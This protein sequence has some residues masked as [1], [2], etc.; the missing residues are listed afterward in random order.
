TSELQG[1]VDGLHSGGD[2]GIFIVAEVGRMRAGRHD[3]TVVGIVGDPSGDGCS[4]H[5]PRLEVEAG[6]FGQ[7]HLHVFVAPQ[8]VTEH[9]CDLSGGE[10]AGSHLVQE[11]LEQ[12]VVSTVY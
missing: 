9:R 1:V 10:N 3:Q 12:V 2:Q 7:D 11:R 5:D 8:L 4:V 6:D